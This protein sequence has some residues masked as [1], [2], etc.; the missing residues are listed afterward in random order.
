MQ[1]HPPFHN[2]HIFSWL[3]N[4]GKT[5]HWGMLNGLWCLDT[6]RNKVKLYLCVINWGTQK[7]EKKVWEYKVAFNRSSFY[8]LLPLLL[9]VLLCWWTQNLMVRHT[10]CLHFPCL[11]HHEVWGIKREKWQLWND[12]YCIPILVKYYI[13]YEKRRG[14]ERT[15]LST[16]FHLLIF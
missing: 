5:I 6:I 3:G 12:F 7:K 9:K 2:T 13:S 4:L 15:G 10:F 1:F 8:N 14:R 11:L 16:I